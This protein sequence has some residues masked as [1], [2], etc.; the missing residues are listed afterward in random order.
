VRVLLLTCPLLACLSLVK[1]ASQVLS[2]SCS[3]LCR[4]LLGQN[5]GK[6]A[7]LL[8]ST[9]EEG[10]RSKVAP[11]R[12]CVR[13]ICTCLLAA[14]HVLNPMGGVP[15]AGSCTAKLP[16]PCACCGHACMH[17]SSVGLIDSQVCQEPL[18]ASQTRAIAT[19]A[20]AGLQ[21]LLRCC[22]SCAFCA[23][24][25]ANMSCGQG[26]QCIWAVLGCGIDCTQHTPPGGRAAS[27]F[28]FGPSLICMAAHTYLAHCSTSCGERLSSGL[29]K[30]KRNFGWMCLPAFCKAGC[31]H[32][33]L[34]MLCCPPAVIGAE[35]GALVSV[36]FFLALFVRTTPATCFFR[37]MCAVHCRL[38][39]RACLACEQSEEVW[40]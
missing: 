26:L 1:L 33:R 8:V 31:Q 39:R 6:C 22:R 11:L 34:S 23:A 2:R 13:P 28:C 3:F 37:A 16:V 36:L 32:V 10:A 27:A 9:S 40:A 14:A 18:S 17:A 20:Q 12:A 30:C 21:D 15:A 24:P 19:V 4:L 38:W 25:A 7:R 5:A 29:G 35:F